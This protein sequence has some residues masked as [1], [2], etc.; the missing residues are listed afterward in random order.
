MVDAATAIQE[1][2]NRRPFPLRISERERERERERE[3]RGLSSIFGAARKYCSGWIGKVILIGEKCSATLTVKLNYAPNKNLSFFLLQAQTTTI[4]HYDWS[5]LDNRDIRDKYTW[6]LRNKFDARQEIS[7]T[8]T[9][10]DEYQNF[11]NAHS[12]AAAE[13][14]LTKQ[15]TK[16]RVTG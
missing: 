13:C 1:Q 11:V 5:L 16:L 10:N 3:I 9:L 4:V 12:E 6:T 7:G 15:R 14:I 2:T 8:P